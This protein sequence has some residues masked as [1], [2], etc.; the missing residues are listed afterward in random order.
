VGVF[1]SISTPNPP[2][3]SPSATEEHVTFTTDT[4]AAVTLFFH[5]ALPQLN[6]LD[7][8]V[9]VHRDKFL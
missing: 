5:P 4:L 2:G 1:I 8:Q 3:T 9:T 7:V 6:E